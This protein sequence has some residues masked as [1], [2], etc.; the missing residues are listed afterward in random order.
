LATKRYA[1]VKLLSAGEGMSSRPSSPPRAMRTCCVVT[2][3]CPAGTFFNVMTE[4]CEDCQRG[5]YQPDEAQLTCLVCPGNTS[6]PH[7][8]S[9]SV[10]Q[11]HGSSVCL[12]VCHKSTSINQC[13]GSS[14]CLSVCHKSTDINQCHGRSVC[15]SVCHKST[16]INQCHGTSVCLSVCLSQLHRH[17]PVPR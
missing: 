7:N 12:S 1:T 17:Q 14:V 2:V 15:L 6:T 4:I 16:S 11:C 5:T 13:H 3:A 9:T 8:S 10:N